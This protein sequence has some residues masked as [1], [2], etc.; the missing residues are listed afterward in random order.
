MEFCLFWN[1]S[2]F[3]AVSFALSYVVFIIPFC[4]LVI[5]LEKGFMF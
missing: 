1:V 3:A 5:D 2:L 4:E